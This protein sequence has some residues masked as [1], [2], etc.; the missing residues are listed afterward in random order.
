M[1]QQRCQITSPAASQ[2]FCQTCG[3]RW[4]PTPEWPQEPLEQVQQHYAA[5]LLDEGSS[6][7]GEVVRLAHP[8]LSIKRMSIA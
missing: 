6:R 7:A 3:R 4:H 5:W 1:T 8:H 2:A